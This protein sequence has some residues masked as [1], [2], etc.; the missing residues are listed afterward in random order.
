MVF[1]FSR[2]YRVELFLFGPKAG[3]W[4]ADGPIKRLRQPFGCIFLKIFLPI[5][6]RRAW[7]WAPDGALAAPKGRLRGPGRPLRGRRGAPLPLRP[8]YGRPTG[9]PQAP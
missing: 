8:T 7:T 1:H 4:P 3:L 9:H 2:F 5:V 6:E